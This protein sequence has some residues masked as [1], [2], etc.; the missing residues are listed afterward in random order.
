MSAEE[1][2]RVLK[3][4]TQ[5][6]A[7]RELNII[8]SFCNN[9]DTNQSIVD[10][11]CKEFV[12]Q[13]PQLKRYGLCLRCEIDSHYKQVYE[14]VCRM[15]NLRTLELLLMTLPVDNQMFI[16]MTPKS[17]SPLKRLTHLSLRFENIILN[18]TLFASIDIHLPHIQSFKINGK[19]LR[20]HM[21]V[22]KIPQLLAGDY[23]YDS[24]NTVNSDE[25]DNESDND[26]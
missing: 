4:L 12:N 10:Y 23:A 19:Q 24:E 26:Q 17:L 11:L 2:I 5:M 13:W 21:L 18:E 9:P 22:D 3:L 20:G 16:E 6:K 14:S 8:I 1:Y 25:S 15:K 7:L